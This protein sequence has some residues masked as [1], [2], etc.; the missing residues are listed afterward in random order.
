[1]SHP[2]L[3][4]LAMVDALAALLV[5]AA[6]LRAAAVLLGWEPGSASR[7]QLALERGLEA[8]SL[9][10]RG[11]A[12]LLAAGSVLA[13]L[14]VASVLPA[15]V[16]GA[17]CGTGVMT[18]LGGLGSRALTLRVLALGALT[19]WATL[20]HLDRQDPAAP[21]ALGLSRALLVAS[22]LVVLATWDTT[23]AF[24]GLDTHSPV[25]CCAVVYDAARPG[26]LGAAGLPDSWLWAFG[27]GGA[28]VFAGALKQIIRPG[29]GAVAALVTLAW[30]PLAAHVLVQRLA[31]YHYEV[32]AHRCP[33][34]LFLPEH[35]LV[36][37][38]LFGALAILAAAALVWLAAGG[39][40]RGG[41][42]LDTAALRL[43]QRA[44]IVGWVALVVFL[45][46]SVGPA[47]VWRLRYGVWMG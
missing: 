14:A 20:D 26:G 22:P 1:M 21:L 36:G 40:L 35:A 46:L 2:L 25:D 44:G 28:L 4:A 13:L 31:A 24:A 10:A 27:A 3:L 19:V 37:Y 17:M 11:G 43:L 6:T 15:V 16:P 47:W 29:R 34:C 38:P 39:A 41:R 9:Q 12:L 30:V 7:R 33:W 5:V 45:V 23:R 8:A 42:P 18:A 32:L